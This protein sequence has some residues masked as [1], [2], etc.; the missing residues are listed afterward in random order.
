MTDIVKQLLAEALMYRKLGAEMTDRGDFAHRRALEDATP[1]PGAI[2]KDG[3]GRLYRYLLQ[4]GEPK[5]DT[6]GN[7][8]LK[9]GPTGVSWFDW[10]IV[11]DGEAGDSTFEKM[12]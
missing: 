10:E 12:L 2:V 3:D 9:P 5:L 7:G 6:M 8:G 4:D 1:W 11:Q